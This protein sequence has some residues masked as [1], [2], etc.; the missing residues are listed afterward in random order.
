MANSTPDCLLALVGLSAAG[1]ACFPLPE[2]AAAL[3]GITDS[4]SGYYVDEVPGLRLGNKADSQKANDLYDRLALARRV[5]TQEVRAAL[6]AGRA[7][8][9]GVPRF[10]QRGTLGGQG[11]GQLL[12]AGTRALLT[13]CTAYAREGAWRLSRLQVYASQPLTDAPLLLDGSQVALLSTDTSGKASGLPA[14]GVLIPLDG[15]RHTLEVVLPDGARVRSNQ[16][17]CFGCNAGSPWALAVKRAVTGWDNSSLAY[18]FS[19]YAAEECLETPD[20]LCFAVGSDLA[21]GPARYPDI[22]KYVAKAIQY[23]AAAV[24]LDGLLAT[25]ATGRY[26]MLEPKGL[27]ELRDECERKLTTAGL[28]G[29]GNYLSWLNSADGLGQVQHPCYLTPVARGIG[30]EWT[31]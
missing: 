7:K 16:L 27:A 21:D 30:S 29:T 3:P 31:L 20:L 24:F 8:S 6:E 12:P 14:E 25:Q 9:Y 26:T 15:Q 18:G 19:F 22:V 28:D 4:L 2:E 1:S 17:Y 10:A 23:K 13:F 11:N 5:A